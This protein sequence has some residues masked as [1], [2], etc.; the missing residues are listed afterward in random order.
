M[1][2]KPSKLTRKEKIALQQEKVKE[3]KK[4]ET[5]WQRL[6]GRDY[7]MGALLAFIG[8]LLYV[9]TL[10]HGFVLDDVSVI[11]ANFHV[12]KGVEGISDIMKSSYRAGYW[13]GQDELYRPLSLVF[14][15]IQWELAPDNP[16]PG[17]W[18]NI[19]L[20]ALTAYLLFIMLRLI[21][22]QV[23]PF[24]LFLISL[25]YVA[26]P[27]HTE[28][29]AN[30]KSLD[31]ILS[32]LFIIVS[33]IFL[34]KYVDHRKIL[35]LVAAIF[36]YFLAF[37]SKESAI[38]ILA[39]IPVML[40]FFRDI[41]GGALVKYTGFMA[42]SAA[43]Y[44]LLRR[45]IL[46]HVT[47]GKDFVVVDNLL[48]AAPDFI[49]RF[50]T[51][52][53]ILGN[54]LLLLFYP[55]PLSSDYSYNEFPIVGPGDW[56]FL[57][58]LAVY[59]G[60]VIYAFWRLKKKE[61]LVFGILFYLFTMSIYSNILVLIGTSFGERLLYMPSFGW[62]VAITVLLTKVFKISIYKPTE[63]KPSTFYFDKRFA[64]V[65]GIVAVVFVA[66][67]FKTI[68]RN[69]D[70]ESHYTLYS[71]DVN[72][73]PNSARIHY[74]YANELMQTKAAKEAKNEEEKNKY[75]EEAVKEYSRALEI[76]PK[77]AD[78]YGQRGLAYFRMGNNE[79]A[80][81]DYNRAIAHNTSMAVV[82]SNL[83]VLYFNAG[84]FNKALELYN[85]AVAYDPRFADGWR[86]LGST[87]GE[88]GKLQEALKAFNNAV[89]FDPE[90]AENW[91]Y[92]AIT[93]EVMGDKRNAEIYFNRAFQLKPE[94]RQKRGG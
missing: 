48:V 56:K 62:A 26:H 50:A 91:Y 82:F 17:H 66:F 40:F 67:A 92:L 59:A 29:V 69:K 15:A 21:M 54:Y 19:I 77:Y 38:T 79:K 44:L 85:K 7:L 4:S 42:I 94:L 20:Y 75:L 61:V 88:M 58:S 22:R 31:E 39:V 49:H 36:F 2:K 45:A 70:W 72:N 84:D 6:S 27:I 53:K 12:Q 11:T 86:N 60:L 24:V 55:N 71:T 35:S 25:L 78:A 81:E 89:K 32:F 80:F 1:S 3:I 28:V 47:A 34:I 52:V 73:T 33:L 5:P 64:P 43:V 57:L 30:I 87:Y 13:F 51:A 68:D 41:K 65:A 76:H 74:F 83:G 37:L 16:L 90:N 93:Y 46:G 8:F 23:N 10:G 18:T 14:F 63:I 9:N